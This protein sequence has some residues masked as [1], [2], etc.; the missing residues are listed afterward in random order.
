MLKKFLAFI[1]I[2]VAFLGGGYLAYRGDTLLPKEEVQ[3]PVEKKPEISVFKN[4]LDPIY[5][6]PSRLYIPDVSIDAK[7]IEIGT[8]EEGSLEAPSLWGELGWYK[9]SA[10]TGQTG[11]LI[12]DGH[13]DDNFGRPAAF[14]SLKNL[15]L[16]AKVYLV[17]SYGRVYTY[18]VREVFFLDIADPN[19]LDVLESEEGKSSL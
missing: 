15:E 16:D 2:V 17:D 19:R 8:D 9:K 14:W 7:I 11:N 10:R 4:K 6:N 5:G 18:K 1:L 13:Y 12:V 3:T